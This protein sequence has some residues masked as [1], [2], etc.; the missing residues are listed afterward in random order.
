M[1]FFIE[2]ATSSAA[3]CHERGHCKGLQLLLLICQCMLW[4]RSCCS[5][6]WIINILNIITLLRY[7]ESSEIFGIIDS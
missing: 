2:Y 5:C 7:H 1:C 3:R 4:A 6:L